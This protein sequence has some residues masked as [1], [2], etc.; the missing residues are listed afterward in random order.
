ML[1]FT[2]SSDRSFT[3]THN[4]TYVAR[5]PVAYGPQRGVWACSSAEMLL[6]LDEK[7]PWSWTSF[8]QLLARDLNHID[9]HPLRFDES[10]DTTYW[11][12]V[13]YDRVSEEIAR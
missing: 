2:F 10:R 11:G 1:T 6:R 13:Q 3:L 9:W 4:S 8:R 7:R 5:D 12:G